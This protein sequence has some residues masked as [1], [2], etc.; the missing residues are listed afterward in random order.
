[1]SGKIYKVL[2]LWRGNQAGGVQSEMERMGETE[3]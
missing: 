3:V 2:F 1:M